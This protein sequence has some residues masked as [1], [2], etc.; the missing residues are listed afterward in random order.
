MVTKQAAKIGNEVLDRGG[1][2]R[3]GRGRYTS[4]AFA[5]FDSGRLFLNAV[6]ISNDSRF[7]R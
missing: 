2:K 5:A 6:A 3:T 7:L 1:M 4:T